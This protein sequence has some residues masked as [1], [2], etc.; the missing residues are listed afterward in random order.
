[1][2]NSQPYIEPL[3]SILRRHPEDS[4]TEIINTLRWIGFSGLG[5][6][7]ALIIFN[8]LESDYP[9][10]LLMSVGI[11]PI[12]IALILIRKE[13]ISIP[14]TLLA[15]TFILEVTALATI[16]QGVYDVGVLAYPVIL[17]IA[18]LILRGRIILY[19]SLLIIV[20]LAWLS[21]G[22][23]W[24]W[25]EPSFITRTNPED[26]FISSAIVLIAGNAVY[27]LAR[28]VYYSL[29][30]AEQEIQMRMEAEQKREEVINQ[31]SEKIRNWIVLRS[32]FYM[33]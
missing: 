1:M 15:V 5:I 23:L 12:I 19:L 33:I 17:I 22:D 7:L 30:R 26:F 24:N 28:N 32:A 18:G 20:C 14:S 21:L 29:F 2:N 6:F 25:Y 13:A 8:L 31:W 16:N 11:V 3:S 9:S 4:K 10:V 27:R